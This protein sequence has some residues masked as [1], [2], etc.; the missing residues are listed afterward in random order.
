MKQ[1]FKKLF[2]T[3]YNE[4]VQ[5]PNTGHVTTTHIVGGNIPMGL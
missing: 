3:K 5:C 1:F 4:V 2:T